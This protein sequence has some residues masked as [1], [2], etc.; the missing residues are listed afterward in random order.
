MEMCGIQSIGVLA[1]LK[2]AGPSRSWCCVWAAATF[3]EMIGTPCVGVFEHMK[4]TGRRDC[5]A[6]AFTLLRFF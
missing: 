1:C 4:L 5:A 3:L 2:L 6:A